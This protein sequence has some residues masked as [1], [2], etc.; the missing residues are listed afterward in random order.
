[1]T[2]RIVSILILIAMVVT[3]QILFLL[4]GQKTV[5]RKHLFYRMD[6]VTEITVVAPSGYNITPL[7]KEIDELLEQKERRY[8]VTHRDSEIR[9]LND[10]DSSTVAIGPAAAEIIKTGIEYGDTLNGLFDITILPIKK[11]WGFGENSDPL[12]EIPDDTEIKEALS[13]VDYKGVTLNSRGDSITFKNPHTQLDVGGLAKGFVI[14]EVQKFIL[15]HGFNDYLIVAGG[16]VVLSGK[17]NDGHPWRVGVQH[18]RQ[19]AGILAVVSPDNGAIVTS[20]DYERYTMFEGQ[21]YHHIF[22]PRTGYSCNENQSVTI[23]TPDAVSADILSTGLF[24]MAA[25]DIVAF[26]E[27]RDGYECIVVSHDGE[28]HISEGWKEEV[29][30]N[31]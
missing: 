31:P 30:V 16:D 20:G 11:L 6:T 5:L 3:A 22:D 9:A 28:V 1:M 25:Q 29:A 14:K 27:Q 4:N 2:K 13:K 21:R 15:E 23:W 19:R 12:K 8:S 17:R 24:C 18:P 10:R 7:W 26:I